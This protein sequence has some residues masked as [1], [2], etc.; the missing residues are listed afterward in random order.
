MKKHGVVTIKKSLIS[1]LF[2]MLLVIS[3]V[4][5]AFAADLRV[6]KLVKKDNFIKEVV[7][8]EESMN[9]LIKDNVIT[10]IRDANKNKLPVVCDYEIDGEKFTL[11]ARDAF[12]R[13]DQKIIIN[14]QPVELISLHRNGKI[15]QWT[16]PGKRKGTVIDQAIATSLLGRNLVDD[17]KK[18]NYYP[19]DY[20]LN[21]ASNAVCLPSA[22][23]YETFMLPERYSWTDVGLIHYQMT[24]KYLYPTKL[25]VTKQVWK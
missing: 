17:T 19:A 7:V 22:I 1:I 21:R 25:T 12:L 14:S 9:D 11:Y 24:G 6:V 23:P 3:A 18:Y 20:L 5:I 16:V 4:S 15:Y 13:I 8:R 2:I 10:N